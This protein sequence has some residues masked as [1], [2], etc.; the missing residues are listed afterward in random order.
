MT[1]RH[2]NGR[3]FSE[4][5]SSWGEINKVMLN[6]ARMSNINKFVDSIEEQLKTHNV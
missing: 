4:Q 6:P 5:L 1:S 3:F 2:S